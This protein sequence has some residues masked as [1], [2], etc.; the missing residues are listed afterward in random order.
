MTEHRWTPAIFG[1]AIA[2]LAFAFCV[3]AGELN[4]L[5]LTGRDTAL[6]VP[7]LLVAAGLLI[8]WRS[9][10][11]DGVLTVGAIMFLAGLNW[12]FSGGPPRGW[13]FETIIVLGSLL[14]IS[15]VIHKSHDPTLPRGRAS[16]KG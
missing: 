3:G 15:A 9:E 14:V 10:L 8:A 6:M 7:F 12:A 1:L 5:T 11:A 2:G 13:A 16:P 4:P